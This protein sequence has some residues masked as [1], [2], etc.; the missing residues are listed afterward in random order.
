[1]K[2]FIAIPYFLLAV[3]VKPSNGFCNTC[4][5]YTNIACTAKDLFRVCVDGLPAGDHIKCPNGTICSG[6][7]FV[8]FS[9]GYGPPDCNDCNVCNDDKTFACSDY[10]AFSLC[11]GSNTPD[12]EI[13]TCP[14]ELVC[15]INSATICV[16][17]NITGLGG[18]CPWKDII[19]TTTTP[20]TTSTS[21]TTPTT[22]STSTTT[23]TTT[24]T[25]TTTPTT[26]FTST[27][28]PTTTSTSTT[29]TSTSTTTPTTTFTSTTTPTTT[30]TSTTTRT[31]TSA[32]TPTTTSTST[33]T[34][35]T[36]S[37]S[38]TAPTTT[39]TTTTTPTTTTTFTSTTTPTTT[40]TS[41]A[42]P[43]T[44]S[45][46]T[47]TPTTTF[48]STTTPTTT[49][50][51]NTTPTTTTSTSTT[52]P[53]TTSTSTTTPT[54]TSTTTTTPRYTSS[55]SSPITNT[56]AFCSAKGFPGRYA[57]LADPTCK[58]FVLC[59]LTSGS[60]TGIAY[61]CPKNLYFN[62]A[63]QS[64]GYQRPTRCESINT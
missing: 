12:P 63:T 9:E 6:N 61:K 50:T 5:P 10:N 37:T 53:T 7:E 40:S 48:T 58:E 35:T 36:T 64:C 43:T 55:T 51:S 18:T 44:T 13:H 17:I 23:P 49:S 30:S 41:T 38:T 34:P 52:T 27:T 11:R 59:I 54:T 4:F 42:T 56:D 31:S 2:F 21:T 28:T 22:T 20:A 15:N 16:D 24:S 39:S 33:T 29:T 25:T 1:M 26:T 57:V 19:T 3:V 47:T 46:S 62:E 45:T 60:Y 14:G 32:T 8:C